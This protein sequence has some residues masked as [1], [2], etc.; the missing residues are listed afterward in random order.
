MGGNLN[1]ECSIRE[2]IINFTIRLHFVT[3]F[4]PY[5]YMLDTNLFVQAIQ[6]KR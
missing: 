4:T 1:F 6:F 2:N 5:S 3:K